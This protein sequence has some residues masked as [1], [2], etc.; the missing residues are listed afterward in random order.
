MILKTSPFS[1]QDKKRRDIDNVN[2]EN[3]NIIDLPS[4]QYCFR[5]NNNR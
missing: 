4:Q 1:I 3:P 5:D 2:K